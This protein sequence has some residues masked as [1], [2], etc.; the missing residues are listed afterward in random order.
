MHN[1]QFLQGTYQETNHTKT[2]KQP[3]HRH[4][5]CKLDKHEHKKKL[6]RF[7]NSHLLGYT[8]NPHLL[9][10]TISIKSDIWIRHMYHIR[11]F[12]YRFNQKFDMLLDFHSN[13]LLQMVLYLLILFALNMK[14]SVILQILLQIL[15][16]IEGQRLFLFSAFF[17]FIFFFFFFFFFFL[18]IIIKNNNFFD[19]FY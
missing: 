12:C 13:F 4:Y 3:S 7:L 16:K 14:F 19:K 11:F 2:N 17:Y 1:Y 15:I 6:W 18:E 10:S 8:K 9:I 5:Q